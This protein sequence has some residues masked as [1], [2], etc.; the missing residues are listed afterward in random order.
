MSAVLQTFD[1]AAYKRTTRQQWENAA[2]AWPPVEPPA[3]AMAW[4]RYRADVRDGR[5]RHRFPGSRC[6]CRRR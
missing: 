5:Y 6:C 2:E 1:A 4:S 3:V